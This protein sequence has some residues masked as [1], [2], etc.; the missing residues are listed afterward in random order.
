MYSSVYIYAP[1][2]LGIPALPRTVGTTPRPYTHPSTPHTPT[3]LP[4][5]S[6]G[7]W[8]GGGVRRSYKGCIDGE[9][10]IKYVDD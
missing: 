7:V 6:L 3:T 9:R 8:C 4:Y 5:C 1:A 2:V 10:F